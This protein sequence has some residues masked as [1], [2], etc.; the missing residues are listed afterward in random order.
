MR[1][2]GNENGVALLLVL[3]ITA[4]LAALLSQLSFSTLVDLRLTETYRDTTR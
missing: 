4:L 2:L 3:A 1:S